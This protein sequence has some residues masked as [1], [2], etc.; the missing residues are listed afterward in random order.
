MKS[1]K[2]LNSN[3]QQYFCLNDHG[4]SC[5]TAYVTAQSS[6]CILSCS[7]PKSNAFAMWSKKHYHTPIFNRLNMLKRSTNVKTR[8]GIIHPHL[9]QSVLVL[10]SSRMQFQE[11]HIY[12][13]NILFSFQ[14][15]SDLIMSLHQS[16][17]GE[18]N[19]K[20]VVTLDECK[21]ES[22]IAPASLHLAIYSLPLKPLILVNVEGNLIKN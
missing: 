16:C 21:S 19:H 2:F 14:L 20:A 7:C 3:L 9:S 10:I 8:L 13:W 18:R 6:F 17:R 5:L 15:E 22:E 4:S 12:Y 11:F 1:R